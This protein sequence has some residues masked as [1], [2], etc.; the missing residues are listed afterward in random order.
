MLFFWFS[1]VELN[2]GDFG[3]FMVF[4]FLVFGMVDGCWVVVGF[5]RCDLVVV[6]VDV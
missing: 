1:M 4:E 2:Y 3:E 5:G 6:G